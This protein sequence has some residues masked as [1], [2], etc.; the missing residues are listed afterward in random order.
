MEEQS[1][2]MQDITALEQ[3]E[4]PGFPGMAFDLLVRCYDRGEDEQCIEGCQYV[5]ST[6]SIS[7]VLSMKL[8]ILIAMS[9][10]DW[11]DVEHY[12]KRAEHLYAILFNELSEKA[13]LSEYFVSARDDL[14]ELAKRQLEN[15]PV[16]DQDQD[17][18]EEQPTEPL[19]QRLV[20]PSLEAIV[21][22]GNTQ[23]EYQR[24][25][26]LLE[27]CEDADEIY[28][29]NDLAAYADALQQII[30]SGSVPALIALRLCILISSV[31]TDRS[32]AK[33]NLMIAEVLW[34]EQESEWDSQM[35]PD[36]DSFMQATR[37]ALDLL[38]KNHQDAA[39]T[40]AETVSQA[41]NTSTF[42]LLQTERHDPE[43]P[44]ISR[45][46]NPSIRVAGTIPANAIKEKK[47]KQDP[48]RKVRN[49]ERDP[50]S[51]K[52]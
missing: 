31:V 46:P 18:E 3:D 19:P 40:D 43:R 45:I 49:D 5:L 20:V 35:P 42:E 10:K 2:I 9:S 28:N 50:F 13:K 4:L 8:C 39:A 48:P 16:E 15:E 24:V 44:T 7:D 11:H 47:K 27:D 1:K 29:N 17:Q 6:Y 41:G 34:E 14:D 12:R 26:Y 51:S 52:P 32:L 22:K 38:S 21:G 37:H 33:A 23:E 25:Q 36:V 30:D